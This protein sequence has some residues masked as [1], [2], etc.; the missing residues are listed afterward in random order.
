MSEQS[1]TLKHFFSPGGGDGLQPFLYL[2]ELES[3]EKMTQ[4]RRLLARRAK[5]LSWALAFSEISHKI[6]ELLDVDV[7]GLLATGWEASAKIDAYLKRSEREP[8]E[9][10]LVHLA[11]HK[12][13]SSHQPYLEIRVNG[14]TVGRIRA[15]V[16]LELRIEAAVLKIEAGR[17]REIRA[18]SCHGQGRF[19]IE[20]IRI[21]EESKEIA[22]P[23]TIRFDSREPPTP[24]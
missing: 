17:I 22:L 5:K 19:S 4:L 16:A 15:E 3:S 21:L 9:A 1:F 8:Q 2:T 23:G 10:F 13:H 20:G 24:P 7:P 11:E 12:L 14:E 18:G 6:P